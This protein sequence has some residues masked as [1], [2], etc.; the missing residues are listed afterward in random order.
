MKIAIYIDEHATKELGGGFSYLS[1]LISLVDQYDFDSQLE[2]V[3]V[4]K[5]HNVEHRLT[6]EIFYFGQY[7]TSPIK[8]NFLNRIINRVFSKVERYVSLESALEVSLLKNNVDLLYYPMAETY[9]FNYPYI[10]TSWDI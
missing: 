3:Y 5:Y 10:M 8:L 7:I 4:T 1:R 2:I 6:K 9:V